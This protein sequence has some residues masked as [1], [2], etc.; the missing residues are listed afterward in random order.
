[1]NSSAHIILK[2]G[3]SYTLRLQGLGAAGYVWEYS[4]EGTEKI[5]A[6]LAGASEEFT[7][8]V[9][10]ES[11]APG[12]SSDEFFTLQAIKPGHAAVRF[13][14]RRPWE[15]NKPPLKEHILEIEVMGS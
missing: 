5:V 6:V 2:V 15:K 8:A 3:E 1:M 14:Q 9:N 12:H 11:P 10:A 13:A 4:M 7:E